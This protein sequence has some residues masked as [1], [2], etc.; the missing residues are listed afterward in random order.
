VI[1]QSH[2][3]ERLLAAIGAD[4]PVQQVRAAGS[5]VAIKR[6]GAGPPVL[7]LH[8]TGH[9][10]GDFVGF[11]ERVGDRFEVIAIDWPGQGRSPPDG[12]PPRARHYAE[13]ALGV[14]E[15]LQLQRPIL[16]GNSIGGA[17]A[18]IAAHKAPEKFSGLVLCNPGGL[19]PINGFAMFAIGRMAAF[20]DAGARR[21]P[22]FDAAFAAYYRCLVLPRAPARMQ[23]DR[24][25]AAG[26]ML[27]PLLADAWRGF[28]EP[29]ADLRGL[30]PDIALPV[31]LAWA[32]SDQLVSW[33][34][35]KKAAKAFRSRTVTLFCGG[36][37]AFLE[38]PDRFAQKFT[39]FA[40][41]AAEALPT[42]AS[43]RTL[44][45]PP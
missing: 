40:A 42:P 22:W 29:D 45:S 37:A 2:P 23:R 24:I 18:L 17:A 43:R 20:F 7:C 39:A 4:L 13:I 8:A 38:D 35:S 3:P 15:A 30:A 26:G 12:L 14:C 44:A 19:A 41:F 5:V 21:A 34:R 32:K 28:A 33:G 25:I 36:H 11:A 27:A 10:S 31:W 16:L 9:G 1:N 6:W